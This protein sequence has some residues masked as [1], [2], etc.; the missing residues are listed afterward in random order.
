MV[1]YTGKNIF[2]LC[3]DFEKFWNKNILNNTEI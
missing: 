3:T 2:D 1:C